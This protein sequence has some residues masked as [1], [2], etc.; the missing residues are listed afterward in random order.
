MHAPLSYNQSPMRRPC[1][2]GITILA[3]PTKI[4]VVSSPA[5]KK[6]NVSFS[7]GK[8]VVRTMSDLAAVRSLIWF[9]A[10]EMYDIK[11]DATQLAET[12]EAMDLA[13]KHEDW[14]GLEGRG[15]EGRWMAYKAR[16]DISNAVLDAQD[17][18]LD[19][20]L[21]AKASR[22]ISNDSVA[23]A[24]ERAQKDAMEAK[25]YCKGV[26]T[27][28]RKP[29]RRRS[30]QQHTQAPRVPVKLQQQKKKATRSSRRASMATPSHTTLVSRIATTT[31][32][33]YSN[34][35]CQRS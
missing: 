22:E 31:N 27:M 14:R 5:P 23:Q 26:Q 28:T 13:G 8:D 33:E 24:N 21:I 7:K 11:A 19:A 25:E 18:H 4:S 34:G 3:N 12:L 1:S 2:Y 17:E 20:I 16:A 6:K 35:H 32:Y 30:L 29:N 10:D 9:T 15:P